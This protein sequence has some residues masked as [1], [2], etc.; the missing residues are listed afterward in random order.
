[1][2]FKDLWTTYFMPL[3]QF[4]IAPLLAGGGVLLYSKY[5]NTN[6]DDKDKMV[7]QLNMHHSKIKRIVELAEQLNRQLELSDDYGLKI[8]QMNNGDFSSVKEELKNTG[9]KDDCLQLF[10]MN[11]AQCNKEMYNIGGKLKKV[12]NEF[13]E[14]PTDLLPTH[15]HAEIIEMMDSKRVELETDRMKK[16]KTLLKKIKK[17]M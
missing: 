8:K 14:L 17:A 16:Y 2:A 11:N 9:N 1:M 5:K 15:I 10:I 13:K 12:F 7:R 3:L 6:K 4:F